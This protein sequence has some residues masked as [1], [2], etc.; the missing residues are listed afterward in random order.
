MWPSAALCL[1][2][3]LYLSALLL[4][5]PSLLCAEPY[6]LSPLCLSF[7]LLLSTCPTRCCF[8]LRLSSPLRV[9]QYFQFTLLLSNLPLHSSHA[10]L[11]YLPLSP[12][13]FCP[14]LALG[15]S[16]GWIQG[17]S[18]SLDSIAHT[19]IPFAL[20]LKCMCRLCTVILSHGCFFCLCIYISVFKS[21]I[22]W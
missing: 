8:F 18:F 11:H 3:H 17:S 20:T 7:L 14:S 19:H 9:T 6:F 15:L 10:L 2:P 16:E 5:I 21:I 13:A 4:N 1:S 22:L 12:P